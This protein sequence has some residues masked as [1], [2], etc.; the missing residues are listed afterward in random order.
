MTLIRGK[1]VT[2][3]KELTKPHS[4]F[5]GPPRT[6]LPTK[7]VMRD[8]LTTVFADSLTATYTSVKA[9]SYGIVLGIKI[10]LV[11]L[12]LSVYKVSLEK[13]YLVL[14]TFITSLSLSRAVADSNSGLSN[15][16]LSFI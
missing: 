7:L 5:S 14:R 8:T 16:T 10:S 1:W 6:K 15:L 4:K 12:R 11:W 2:I 13:K 3:C 9:E